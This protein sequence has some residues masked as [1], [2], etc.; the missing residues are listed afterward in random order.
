[1]NFVLKARHVFK[2]S[3]G[4]LFFVCFC[5]SCIEPFTPEPNETQRLLVVEGHISDS[6]EPYTIRLSRAQPLNGGGSIPESGAA[7]F[8]KNNEGTAYDFTEV[9]PGTYQS[10]PACFKG[11]RGATYQLHIETTDGSKYKSVEVLLKATPPIDSVYF[12]REK[13]FTDVTG[14][15]LDGI[16]ILVD[17]HDPD[18]KTLYYRY[19]WVATYQIKVPFPSQWELGSDGSLTLV[20][21]YHICYDSDTSQTILTTNT[22]QLNQDQVTAFELDYV[23]TIS[24]RLRTMYSILVRQYALDER[25][26]SYWSQLNKNSENLGTLFDPTPYPIVG[27]LTSSTSPDEV[28]LGYFDASSV[29]EKRLY[30][31]RDELDAL[32][33]AFPTNPCVLQADTVKGGYDEMLLRLSW[34]QRIITI[35]GFGSGALIMGPAECSDCRLLGDADAPDVWEN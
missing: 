5:T 25:G 3:D 22:L 27:N 11:V 15:E 34:G 2:G 19:E 9:S 7:V 12:E 32:G 21:F 20:E 33:L 35:P 4:L 16:K 30:V 10:D 18:G 1:M 31:T 13:R 29:K 28:V 6:P 26:H 14:E 23:N 24:Y 17:T 8:V